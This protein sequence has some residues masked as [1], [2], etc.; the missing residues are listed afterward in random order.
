DNKTVADLVTN[1]SDVTWYDAADGTNVVPL[2]T[3]LENNK[4]YYGS[5]KAGNCESPTR[6]AVTVTLSDP[7]TP[8]T[9][10]TT[11]EFCKVDNKTVADLVTN[12]SDVTWY[13]AEKEGNVVPPT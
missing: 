11:Q 3:V 9:A 8:T 7:Q 5:L 12:E 6:L 4:V 13:D 2:T 1:E 10:H